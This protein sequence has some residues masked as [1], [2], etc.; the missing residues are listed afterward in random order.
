MIGIIII[1][2]IILLTPAPVGIDRNKMRRRKYY[3]IF[4]FGAMYLFAALR[5]ENVAIDNVHR[6]LFYSQLCSLNVSD[7]LRYSIQNCD[8]QYGY[9]ITTWFLSRVLFSPHLISMVYDGFICYTFARFFYRHAEDV[10]IAALMY[11]AFSFSASLNVTRQFIAC[12]FFIWAIECIVTNRLK[13]SVSLII[14]ATLFHTTAIALFCVYG[15]LF[16]NFKISRKILVLI[17]LIAVAVFFLFEEISEYLIRRFLP[18]YSWYLHGRWAVGEKSFSI[19]WLIIYTVIA[20]GLF[21]CLRKDKSHALSDIISVNGMAI[22][23]T[24]KDKLFCLTSI[25]YLV[26][27]LISLLTSKVWILGRLKTFFSI[28]YYLTVGNVFIRLPYLSTR[29]KAGVRVLFILGMAAWTVLIY[30]A[31]GNGLFP[32]QF[33]WE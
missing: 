4:T 31:D 27:A 18:R 25:F 24:E 29:S 3:C 8:G 9:G 1:L 19:L 28:G 23:N 6:Y 17:S 26:Y 16:I 11:F 32:Y 30:R 13:W 2:G 5:G 7:G 22:V 14:I 20:I 15:L 10:K 21:M 33:F 12:A